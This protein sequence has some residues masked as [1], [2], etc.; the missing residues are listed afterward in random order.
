MK[1]FKLAVLGLLIT[2]YGVSATE[3]Q[4]L[5]NIKSQ[6]DKDKLKELGFKNCKSINQNSLVCS[7][8]D[9]V[10]Y[11]LQL[12]DFL[13]KNGI[14]A[15]VSEVQK[16]KQENEQKTKVQKSEEVKEENL[17]LKTEEKKEVINKTIK[18]TS[19]EKIKKENKPQEVSNKAETKKDQLGDLVKSMYDYLNSNKF[20]K[21]LEIAKKLENTKY[22]FD[23]KFVIGLINLKKENFKEACY[24]FENLSKTNKKAADLAI[25]SCWVYYMQSGYDALDSGK[26]TEA[27]R[28]FEK[29]LSYKKNIE[30]EIGLFYVYLK[31]KNLKKAEEIITRLYEQNP[32]DK[33]V[34]KAY[35]DYL[36]ETKQ[37]DKLENF[38][39]YLSTEQKNL[40][41]QQS[42][43]SELDTIKNYIK[44]REFDIAEEKLKSLDLKEPNN[45]YVLLNLGY[46]YLEKGE[47]DKAE[48]YYRNVLL[49]DKNNKD[50]LKGLKAIY[51]KL[52]K[53]DEALEIID[54]LKSMG[55]RDEDEKKIRELYLTSKAQEY[56]KKG[57]KDLAEKYALESLEINKNNPTAYI[58]LAQIYKD[59]DKE[60]Y[61]NYISKAYQ[62]NP[63]DNGIKIAYMYSLLDLNLFDQAKTM[64]TTINP[65]SLTLEE[66]DN[67][68]EFYKVFYEKL[69]SYY[70]NNKNYREAKKVAIEGLELFPDNP[71]LLE[72][73]GWACYNLKDY[74]CSEK[75]F[76]KLLAFNQN[77]ESAKLGLAYTYLNLK[78]LDKLETLL[79]SL[80]KSENPKTLEELATIYYSLGR[81]KDADRIIRKYETI[82]KQSLNK[83]KDGTFEVI[84][85]KRENTKPI[86]K[87]D[88]EIPYILDENRKVN[89]D[90][91]EDNLSSQENKTSVSKSS[92]EEVL[93]PVSTNSDEKK[94]E[95][96]SSI[97]EI[98]EKI[99]EAK[100]D[101]VSNIALGV[102]LRNKSGESGKSK[103][104]DLSP[105]IKGI[106]FFNENFS[107]FAGTYLTKL[108]SGNLSDYEHFGTPQNKVILRQVPSS[109]SGLEPFAGFNLTT[110]RFDSY[111]YLGITP[112][113]SNGVSSKIVY[114]FENKIKTQD[115]KFGIGLYQKPIRDSIL[116]YVGTIDPYSSK[117]WGRA[118]ETGLK[119]SYER[120][121]GEKDSMVYSELSVG[122]IKGQD[123]EENTNIN[124]IVM[125]KI[126]IG[127]FIGDEDYLGMFL[128][129]NRFSKN[130]DCYYYDCGGYFSPKTMAIIAPML[131]GFYFL[132]DKL[133]IHYKAFLGGLILNNQGKNS[134][135][136]A[137]DIYLGGVYMLSRNIFL[138]LS[139]EYRK[140]SKY[141]EL[142][143]STYLQYFFGSRYNVNKNDLIK[144]EKEVY[145]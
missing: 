67:L 52:G 106:F 124:L 78:K 105:F 70:L 88:R 101:Y 136:L 113:V 45:I 54:K 27:Y 5:V 127:K 60:K 23:A 63:N 32:N 56:L 123:I 135:D 109:Y 141:S 9:N 110:N 134:V 13:K 128:L 80:D 115:S 144:L 82:A 104:T 1:R 16:P 130:Q 47:L 39:D 18:N 64:L 139:G 29:S 75:T 145:K 94:I 44:S 111:G 92:D 102:K 51:V 140:T 119:I 12:R 132:N 117:S 34:I 61:F 33:K 69:A 97:E 20:D 10:N 2:T 30:S 96:K 79:K 26:L 122:R 121:L 84:E 68:K 108:N 55:V 143:T 126:Y 85:I 31:Q 83:D 77:S 59:K 57:N 100:Q 49:I 15:K 125:P 86:E 118:T 6:T 46:L 107:V 131:E 41:E 129:Y 14:N 4:L 71:S 38:K 11:L 103:L 21:A 28:Y 7:T 66:K 72:S 25:D 35:T 91:K 76:T 120:S 114:L 93:N 22:R 138:N 19:T 87:V 36:T 53:Y 74:E 98:K 137:T 24:I 48:D 112:K 142:F 8:S 90:Y 3:Y 43:Y 17:N 73:L 62:L 133:G 99:K 65:S 50:A 42:I 58:V 40:V 116:S 81:Y 95:N 37:F 89:F